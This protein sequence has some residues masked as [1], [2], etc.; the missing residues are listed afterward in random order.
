MKLLL[1]VLLVS[2]ALSCASSETDPDYVLV[3]DDERGMSFMAHPTP[4]GIVPDVSLHTQSCH[5]APPVPCD[6]SGGIGGLPE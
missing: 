4:D 6:C 2:L 5:C 3:V 1:I